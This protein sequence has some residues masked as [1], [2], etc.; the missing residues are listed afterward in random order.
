M[1][2]KELFDRIE[3]AVTKYI[4]SYETPF[5]FTDND[6]KTMSEEVSAIIEEGFK[7]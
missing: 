3:E 4:M 2:N 7:L 1:N 6:K 5:V